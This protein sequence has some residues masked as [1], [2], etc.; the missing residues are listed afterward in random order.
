MGAQQPEGMF[1]PA[2]DMLVVLVEERD[3]RRV[4]H[5]D[6][7]VARVA[8]APVPWQGKRHDPGIAPC[9]VHGQVAAAVGAAIVDQHNLHRHALGQH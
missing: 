2:G 5:G 7:D 3:D 8:L 4:G 9:Q 6:P 1:I